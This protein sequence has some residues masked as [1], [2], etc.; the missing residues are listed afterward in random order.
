[1]GRPPRNS[2]GGYVYHV[3][4]R[5][6][7]PKPMFRSEE[8]FAEFEHTLAQAVERFEPRLLAYCV[9][10]KHWHLVLTPRKDGD[11]SKLM[12][13]LMTTHSARW[14]SKPRRSGTGGLYERRFRSFPVQDDV[15]LLDVLGFVESHP[16][17]TGLVDSAIDWHWIPISSVRAVLLRAF[18]A[19]IGKNCRMLHAMRV[20]SPWNLEIGDKTWIGQDVWIYNQAMVRIGSNVVVSQGTFMTCGSH[21]SVHNMDLRVAPIVIEDGAWITSKCFIQKGVTIGRSALVTPLSV[22]HQSI[23]AE[24]VYGGN[25]C[26]FIRKRFP[27]A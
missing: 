8:D 23:E 7:K 15:K 11:L 18:G 2:Q 3:I 13:W 21:D 22:V 27:A 12:G 25:P 10:P 19:K 9:L 14:H 26:K 1:M 4:A 6:L 24:S 17:R 20:K 16:V 5:G